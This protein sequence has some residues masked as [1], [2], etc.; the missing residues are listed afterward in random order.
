MSERQ[1]IPAFR[2][3][4]ALI[5]DIFQANNYGPHFRLWWLGQSGFLLQY[6]QSHLLFDPYLSDSLTRKY[7]GTNK[8][9]VRMSERVVDP[10]EL[11]FVEIVTSSHNHTDHLDRDT[12]LPIIT[13]KDLTHFVLPEANRLFAAQRLSCEASFAVGLDDGDRIEISPFEIHA[14]PSAHDTIER[15]EEGRCRFLGY[16]VRFGEWT[17]YHSGDT[18]L[19]DGLAERLREFHVDV[20]LLPINGADPSRGVAGNLSAQEAAHLGREMGAGVVIPHHYHMFEFNTEDPEVFEAACKEEGTPYRVLRLGECFD[21][22]SWP[23]FEQ[24]IQAPVP[25][26]PLPT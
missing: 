13:A 19:Y 24:R 12:I 25:P 15:D 18:R 10:E 21:S 23:A 16:V 22:S 2:K 14:I 26:E 4:E 17:L 6:K 7:D 9:H 1:L 11:G 3:D 8:P 5:A 20:A